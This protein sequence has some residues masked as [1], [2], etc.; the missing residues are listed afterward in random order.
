MVAG[1]LSGT[2]T[3]LGYLLTSM[4]LRARRGASKWLSESS[5]PSQLSLCLLVTST[6]LPLAVSTLMAMRGPLFLLLPIGRRLFRRRRS[7]LLLMVLALLPSFCQMWQRLKVRSYLNTH[8]AP[9]MAL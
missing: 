5:L 7:S 1:V 4:L 2:R 8:Q 6:L 9:P 3:L